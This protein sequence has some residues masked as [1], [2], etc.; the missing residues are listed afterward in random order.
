MEIHLFQIPYDSANRDLRMGSGPLHF[1]S[2]GIDQ[3]LEN[4]GYKVTLETIEV[5]SSFLAEIKTA[6]ELYNLLA[7]RVC[8]AYK[9]DRFPFILSGN[10]NSALG[11]IAGIGSDHLGIIMTITL[12]PSSRTQPTTFST[13]S[14]DSSITNAR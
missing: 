4:A 3:F 14:P 13:L 5:K 12:I 8:E 6:F 10:C 7:D 9:S 11:T 2:H 1:S